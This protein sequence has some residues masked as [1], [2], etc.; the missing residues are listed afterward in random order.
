[1]V[2]AL[3]GRG[4]GGR[5][6]AVLIIAAGGTSG[7]ASVL[8]AAGRQRI[9]VQHPRRPLQRRDGAGVAQLL[10][11]ERGRGA[12]SAAA[13]ATALPAPLLRPPHADAAL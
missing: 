8:Q 7:G 2:H 5:V 10:A 11:A 9:L 12:G 3:C 6:A 4:S 13:A 1:M